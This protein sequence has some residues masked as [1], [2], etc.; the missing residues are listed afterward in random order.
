LLDGIPQSIPANDID[1]CWR[2][3]KFYKVKN[4]CVYNYNGSD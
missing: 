2:P 3:F 4:V 1:H